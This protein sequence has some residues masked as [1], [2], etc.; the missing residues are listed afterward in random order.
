[1]KEKPSERANRIG[2][3]KAAFKQIVVDYPPMT[4]AIEVIHELRVMTQSRGP[5]EPCSPVRLT[6][7][8]GT[9]KSMTLKLAAAHAAASAPDG[10]RPVLIVQMPTAGTTDSIPSAILKSLGHP[11][12]DL[13]KT[14]A[15]WLRA[16]SE[17]RRAG[18]EV[19]AFD[20]FNRASRRPT[21]SRPI[22]ISIREHILD[23]GVAAVAFVGTAEAAVVL[24]QCDDILDRLEGEID[25]SPME[26]S[27]PDDRDLF[28]QFVE[29]V[30][31]ALVSHGLL[32]ERSNLAKVDTAMRLCEASAGRLRPLMGIIGGAMALTLR[33][34]GRAIDN[35][36]LQEAVRAYAMRTGFID[37]NPF[38]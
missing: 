4:A 35:E 17:M 22:A 1:M 33:R 11:R 10:Q 5:G 38:A 16:I 18:V 8:I 28:V 31:G 15:R 36:D 7:P 26:W 27:E 24:R 20:E 25:L 2:A 37:R 9:G 23:D 30:D 32:P 34:D 12:P 29:D 3:A 21:M 6:A 13:G 19:I 14:D